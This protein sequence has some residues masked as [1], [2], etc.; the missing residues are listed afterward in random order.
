MHTDSLVS[1]AL[2][3]FTAACLE[4][5]SKIFLNHVL[6]PHC[7]FLSIHPS[8]AVCFSHSCGESARYQPPHFP[9]LFMRM[10]VKTMMVHLCSMPELITQPAVQKTAGERRHSEAGLKQFK[11]MCWEEKAAVQQLQAE[12]VGEGT[13]QEWGG[14]RWHCQPG[15]LFKQHKY[16]KRQGVAPGERDGPD[17]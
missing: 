11:L 1:P 8:A 6:F 16:I 2:G 7:S 5:T 10:I 17:R 15:P 3:I 4:R 12:L 14:G 9:R 13:G